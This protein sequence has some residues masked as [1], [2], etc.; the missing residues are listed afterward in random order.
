MTKHI[1]LKV[2]N[3]ESIIP[4]SR[5]STEV[6]K[7][8][9]WSSRKAFYRQKISP[10]REACPAGN[11][12]PAMLSYAA[13]GDF[14]TALAS[15]LME[16]PLPAVCGRVCYHPCQMKC[17]RT[18]FDET[19]EIRSLERAIADLGKADPRMFSNPEDRKTTVGVVG[20]GPAGLSAAYFLR[21][22][23]HKVAIFESRPDPGGV[24]RYGI[25]EYRLPKEVL[26]R[27]IGRMLGLGIE[28][29]VNE[30]IDNYRLE[31][32]RKQFKYIFLGT[33]AWV[34]R[35]LETAI[36]EPRRVVY[37]LDFLSHEKKMDFCEG[38]KNIVIIGGGD[39]A[40]DVARTA[41]RFA[42]AKLITMVAP[43]KEG[44]FPCDP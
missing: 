31:D 19:V 42:A 14:D 21:L 36:D 34:P 29:K 17:N 15:L 22:F 43:E 28:L 9:Q 44:E 37:G 16:N 4:V 3:I 13:K 33:G 38:K 18:Q 2:E 6:F 32:L 27:E 12:I 24:L 23:G 1:S 8:G 10:C 30:R 20:S 7:T 41:R 25:P 26:S 11:D 35:R 39:V 5:V 40:V